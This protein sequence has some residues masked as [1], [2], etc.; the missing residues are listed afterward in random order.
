MKQ[1]EIEKSIT[2][3]FYGMHDTE[4][5]ILNYVKSE[6]RNLKIEYVIN[7]NLFHLSSNVNK[8]DDELLFI[9]KKFPNCIICGSLALNLV[10]ILDRPIGDIDILIDKKEINFISS[11][12][13][14]HQSYNVPYTFK[15]R[16][17]C[18]DFYYKKNIFAQ[19][20]RFM[21]DFYENINCNY[22]TFNYKNKEIKIQNPIDI[23]GSKVKVA[24]NM[25]YLPVKIYN[26]FNCF[27]NFCK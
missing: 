19:T 9:Q 21:V 23:I 5:L 7:N 14:Y 25:N 27:V 20:K 12:L 1:E 10:G 16:L 2:P 4:L 13:V 3:I 17:G 18:F 8:F 15:N 22:I 24:S 6:L 11:E 26:D